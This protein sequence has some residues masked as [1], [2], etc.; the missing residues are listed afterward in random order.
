[1][2]KYGISLIFM[3][4][5]YSGYTQQKA[6]CCAASAT[7]SFA[8]LAS[9]I[10][11]VLSHPVPLPFYFQSTNGK[12][13]RFKTPDG[14]DAYGWE[15]RAKQSTDNYIFVIHEWWGLNDY[16]KQEAEGLWKNLGNVNVIAID[17]YDQ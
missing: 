8:Q 13:I 15:I 3:L 1:M 9:E 7:E 6:S 17:L 10:E 12:N 2:K 4:I 16:I 11:F 5:T 14:T